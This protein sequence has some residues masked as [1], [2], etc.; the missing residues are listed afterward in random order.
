MD[1]NKNLTGVI[2]YNITRYNG[3]SIEILYTALNKD[4]AL[5][6]FMNS[7]CNNMY[8]EDQNIDID[9]GCEGWQETVEQIM[10]TDWSDNKYQL[11]E[12]IIEE[13]VVNFRGL[14]DSSDNIIK[15][16][17]NIANYGEDPVWKNV[18]LFD[19]MWFAKPSESTIR[20]ILT[21][22]NSH[23][24][25]RD[26]ILS[27][28]EYYILFIPNR[29]ADGNMSNKIYFSKEQAL[30][31]VC[32]YYRE[33]YENEIAYYSTWTKEQFQKEAN[34]EGSTIEYDTFDK[35]QK[36]LQKDPSIL[37]DI[38]SFFND[39]CVELDCGIVFGRNEYFNDDD[40]YELIKLTVDV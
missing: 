8:E 11:I 16:E 30:N 38:L 6:Y 4:K 13:E 14:F 37:K 34:D 23:Q 29:S 19:Q 20:D 25:L 2:L 10:D 36:W 18:E 17:K 32:K 26:A 28:A 31:G 3:E 24:E 12:S 40:A 33:Q 15:A 7:I 1:S 35:L 27:T 21:I 5:E 22:K 9:M 39:M